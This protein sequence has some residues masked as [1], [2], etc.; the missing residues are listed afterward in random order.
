MIII[1]EESGIDIGLTKFGTLR[2]PQVLLMT[3]RDQQICAC[4]YHENID[5]ILSGLST[6]VKDLPHHSKEFAKL[7]VYDPFSTKCVDRNCSKCGIDTVLHEFIEKSAN[8]EVPIKYYQW[9]TVEKR[10]AK[11]MVQSTVQDAFDDLKA[12]LKP[13][14]WHLY[15]IKRQYSDLKHL[16]ENLK[17]EEIIVHEDFAENFQIK[18]QNEIIAAHWQNDSVSIFP[19]IVYFILLLLLLQRW[20]RIGT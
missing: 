17:K 9:H 16:K 13:F 15:N 19:I 8:P 3:A 10:V 4:K 14:S 6:H 1:V 2:P 12:Q 20:S 11:G 5:L 7:T 18:Q